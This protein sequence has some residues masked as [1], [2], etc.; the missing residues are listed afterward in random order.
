MKILKYIYSQISWSG[1]GKSTIILIAGYYLGTSKLSNT[2]LVQ[3][4]FAF[5]SIILYINNAMLSSLLLPL[6]PSALQPYVPI[7]GGVVSLGKF[8]KKANQ[9]YQTSN[10]VYIVG[11]VS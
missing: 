2:K 11:N 1:L 3:F 7:M 5:F 10:P 9:L 4:L 8:L 6:I